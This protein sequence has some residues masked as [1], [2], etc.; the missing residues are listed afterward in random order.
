MAGAV[1][2]QAQRR[3]PD[4]AIVG[5]WVL[6]SMQAEGENKI[7]LGGSYSRVKYY[8]AKG[9]YACAEI[10][11]TGNNK[12]TIKP[13]EYGT[14]TY[15]R[16]AYTEMG[17]KG[18]FVIKGNTGYGKWYTQHEEWRKVKLPDKLTREIVTRCRA[19]G[20]VPADVQK[21]IRRYILDR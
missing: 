4:R 2:S 18:I 21:L 1:P 13:H 10:I 9:E 11:R 20:E 19:S 7:V 14:Y 8:G 3:L 6:V 15:H 12:Y 17:R 16:G 5:T